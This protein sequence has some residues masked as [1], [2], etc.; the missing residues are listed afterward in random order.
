MNPYDFVRIDWS[1]PPERRSPIWHHRLVSQEG[2]RLFA[3][4]LEVDVYAETPLFI[5]DPRAVSSDPKKPDRFI[6]N[7]QGQYIIP[8]SSLKGLLRGLVETLGNGCLTLFDGRYERGKTDYT[9][10]IPREFQ[11][12]SDTDK[13]CIACRLFGTLKERSRSI[14]LGKVNIGDAVASND[15]VYL[16]DPIYTKPL[17]EPK[18]HH[19]SFYLDESKKHIAGRKYYFHHSPDYEPLT[20]KGII[21]MGGRPANR[22]IQPLDHDTKFHFRIDF[23]NL[24]ADEF[25]ALLLAVVL[26]EHMR[27]KIGYGK[28]LGLG[29]VYLYPTHLTLIDYARRYSQSDAGRGKTVL[30]EESGLWSFMNEQLDEFY[31]KYLVQVAMDDLRRIWRWPPERD[32]D[33]YYPSKRDWFDTPA[34]RGK[35]I[36]DTRNV[37]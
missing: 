36:A 14:F 4:Q 32:V 19:E 21:R 10:E 3:G 26:E 12:C 7:S 22:F 5:V 23:T 33:Y 35:R 27:H 16:Y 25:A 28:P 31:E 15:E 20:E 30:E 2:K 17:M 1:R 9:R 29:S 37:P 24:E 6:Q 8:G 34:S 18:P 13:L 11:H